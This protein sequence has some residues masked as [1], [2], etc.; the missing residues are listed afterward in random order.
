VLARVE[1]HAG[2]RIDRAHALALD[3]RSQLAVDGGHALE[4][5]IAGDRFRTLLDREVEVVGQ[6]QDLADEVL[7]GQAEVALALFGRAPLEVEELRAFALERRQVVVR[8]GPRG[9]PLG[10]CR[11]EVRD[12][13]GR[14]DVDRVGALLG[15]RSV[16]RQTS[17]PPIRS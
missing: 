4:P 13:L 1:A 5:R 16:A 10:E 8:L 9:I 15:A 11:L 2:R 17:G 3:Q 14:T 6:R 12:Q 7:G